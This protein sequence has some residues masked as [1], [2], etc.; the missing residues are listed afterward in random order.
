MVPRPGWLR[1]RADGAGPLSS[2]SSVGLRP[3][4]AEH[5]DHRSR[6]CRRGF[7]RVPEEVCHHLE[8]F[9]A[10]ERRFDRR[11]LTREADL[12]SHRCRVVH[13]VQAADADTPARRCDEGGD[14]SEE[15]RLPGAVRTDKCEHLSRAR[16]DIEPIER[17]HLP[18]TNCEVRCFEQRGPSRS[19]DQ[20]RHSSQYS[21]ILTTNIKTCSR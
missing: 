3:L 21:I 11:E 13:N 5:L 1:D 17:L 6:C 16:H 2:W 10:R 9:P 14:G 8:V 7:A 18:V 19:I 12:T 20:A 4:R 15:R